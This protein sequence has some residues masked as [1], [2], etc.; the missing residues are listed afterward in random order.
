MSLDQSLKYLQLEV[1]Q[2]L[3]WMSI[4]L[5]EETFF[6]LQNIFVAIILT[7]NMSTIKHQC[8]MVP[9]DNFLLSHKFYNSLLKY[10]SS[11]IG[12]FSFLF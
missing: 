8:L 2:W 10:F 11:L 3:V 1:L 6:F 12:V 9:P 4:E 7:G 5:L